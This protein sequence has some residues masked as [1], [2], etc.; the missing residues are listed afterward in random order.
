M[1]SY[2]NRYEKARYVL[3]NDLEL[4]PQELKLYSDIG[5]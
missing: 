1:Y 3:D 5:S 2:T 4:N